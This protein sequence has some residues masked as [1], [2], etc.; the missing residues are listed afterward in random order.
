MMGDTAYALS[1]GAPRHDPDAAEL[2]TRKNYLSFGAES[3]ARTFSM[4]ADLKSVYRCRSPVGYFV[5]AASF[6]AS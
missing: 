2:L 1:P 4:K 5:A 3:L 6:T